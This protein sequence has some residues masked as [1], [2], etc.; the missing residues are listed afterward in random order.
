M[1]TPSKSLEYQYTHTILRTNE[2]G[3]VS[4][5]SPD[6]STDKPRF[7]FRVS[8]DISYRNALREF[9]SQKIRQF[10]HITRQEGGDVSARGCQDPEVLA[11]VQ[12]FLEYS[13]SQLFTL[14][15]GELRHARNVLDI[16][17]TALAKVDNA[18]FINNGTPDPSAEI[19]STAT[20]AVDQGEKFTFRSTDIHNMRASVARRLNDAYRAAGNGV[21]QVAPP[22]AVNHGE[23]NLP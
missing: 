7:R 19:A 13:D 10:K 20:R 18:R 22:L 11:L 15:E 9:L 17:E 14:E 1:E 23:P 2:P 21:K 8:D 12:K 16:L 6:L 3:K 5:R 4:P